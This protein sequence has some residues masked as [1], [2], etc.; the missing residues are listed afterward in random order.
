[1]G[2]KWL[3]TN[4][5]RKRKVTHEKLCKF[6]VSNDGYGNRIDHSIASDR[7]YRNVARFRSM[8]VIRWNLFSEIV[9]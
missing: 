1:M 5:N 9:D 4:T 3:T 8:M 7:I 6:R 2:G